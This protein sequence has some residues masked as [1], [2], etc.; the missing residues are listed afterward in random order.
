[1]CLSDNE[2]VNH[3]GDELY[4]RR[5]SAY[6]IPILMN[7]FIIKACIESIS[8]FIIMAFNISGNNHNRPY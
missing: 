2:R 7:D 8:K 1:M 6:D 5:F 4:T 3:Q